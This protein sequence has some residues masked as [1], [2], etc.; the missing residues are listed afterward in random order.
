MG[1]SEWCGIIFGIQEISSAAVQPT[2]TTVKAV[3]N[4]KNDRKLC[5]TTQNYLILHDD[6]SAQYVTR[7]SET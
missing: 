5:N 2:I 6:I 7:P 3:K 4:K 1:V